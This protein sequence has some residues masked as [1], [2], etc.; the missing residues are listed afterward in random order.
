MTNRRFEVER[1]RATVAAALL[2]VVICAGLVGAQEHDR[3]QAPRAASID[4]SLATIQR[5]A[6]FVEDVEFDD[7]D[8]DDLIA[9]WDEMTLLEVEPGTR[10]RPLGL[11]DILD[12]PEYLAFCRRHGLD[13]TTYAKKS[14]RIM[15][16]LMARSMPS[17]VGDPA[18]TQ[19]QIDQL[20]HLRRQLPNDAREQV[21]EQIRD[22]MEALRAASQMFE[23]LPEPTDDEAAVLDAR[24]AELDALVRGRSLLGA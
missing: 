12:Q 18:Q 1:R 15:L 22:A 24:A 6:D 20:E 3:A 4:E 10:Q 7:D 8:V 2:E 14:M 19:A 5:A 16:G 17:H 11:Q 21:E 13:P 9:T 23:Q